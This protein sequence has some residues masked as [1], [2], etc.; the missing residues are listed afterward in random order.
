MSTTP[1]HSERKGVTPDVFVEHYTAGS[2]TALST[3]AFMFRAGNSAHAIIDRE[4]AIVEPVD[5]DRAAWHAGDHNKA[6]TRGSRF[7]SAAQ[8]D[9]LA[10]GAAEIIPIGD[11][12]FSPRL[13]N[14]R[15]VGV[16]HVNLGWA[17]ADKVD[18]FK[19]RHRNPASKD[20]DWQRY[21][22]AQIEASIVF[23]RK[24]IERYPTLRYVT[25][26]EDVCHA[27][28]LG[29]DPTTD[30]IERVVGGKLDPGPAFPWA[31]LLPTLPLIR[32]AYDFK[33]HGWRIDRP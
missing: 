8:L 11:V 4:G 12:P 17:Y 3:A 2:G 27:D 33:A 14:R 6:Q 5:L 31:W 30:K 23:H 15:S 28:A 32:I 1:H 21:T 13:M 26:H 22:Q 16:E 10:I 29:D 25:G 18:A 9:M 7:P 24:A 20:D 19:G